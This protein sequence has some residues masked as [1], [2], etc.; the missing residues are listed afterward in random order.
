V[1]LFLHIGTEKTGSSY[2][3]SMAAQHREQLATAGIY[4][5][6]AGKRD[7]QMLSGEISAGNAQALCAALERGDTSRIQGLLEQHFRAAAQASLQA[8]L[9]SNELLVLALARPGVL[10]LLQR[11][12]LAAGYA[13]LQM[14]LV[15]R[16]PVDQ[17]LSL[18]KHRAK[19][20]T[21]P[22]IEVWAPRHYH[23]APALADFLETVA[24]LDI[25]LTC[26]KYR[27]E[28]GQLECLF[29]KDWLGLN[30]NLTIPQQVVNPS[31]TISE[32]LLLRQLRQQ[33]PHWTELLYR[34][35]LALPK[36]DKA[37]EPCLEAYYRQVLANYLSKQE[38]TWAA[39]NRFLPL[40]E[41]LDWPKSVFAPP[42]EKILSFSEAQATILTQMMGAGLK[43][44]FRWKLRLLAWRRK[45]GKLRGRLMQ[46]CRK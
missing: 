39:C 26:R 40:G 42:G 23:Y 18:Y 27:T 13:T 9:L 29:F 1:K 8:V 6:S 31:L 45:V 14:L 22:D 20:G 37:D 11:S 28:S 21:A 33:Q 38:A 25:Q 12:V 5:P 36:K 7:A 35:M 43:L 3:Q 46:H 32:L 10:E 2:L 34:Q 30:A 17:A 19:G 15:L 24:R 41:T 16:D 4:F 44:T